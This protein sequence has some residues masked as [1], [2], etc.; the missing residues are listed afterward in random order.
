LITVIHPRRLITAAVAAAFLVAVTGAA[1]VAPGRHQPP[2]AQSSVVTYPANVDYASGGYGV[3]DSTVIN[4]SWVQG[5]VINMNWNSVETSLNTF[6]WG[7]LDTEAAA[8]AAK[9]KHVS[10][11]VRPASEV[12]GSGS[13]TSGQILPAWEQTRL[14]ASNWFCDSDVGD[15]VPNWFSSTFQSDWLGFISAL[16]SHIAAQSYASSISYVRIGVGLGAEGFPL[17]GTAKNPD[18]TTDLSTITASWGYSPD[19]FKTFQETMLSAYK[20]AI[21]GTP[22]SSPAFV[23]DLGN[24]GGTTAAQ[25]IT[26]GAST[27]AGDRVIIAGRAVQGGGITSVTDS[28]G[29]TYTV[30]KAATG[31]ESASSVASANLATALQSGDTITVSFSA[32]IHN[33]AAAIEA[34]GISTTSPVDQTA[35]GHNSSG[36]TVTAATSA[37]DAQ[38]NEFVFSTAAS[39]AATGTWSLAS[40]DPLSGGTWHQDTSAGGMTG[41]GYELPAAAS[42][43][44]ATYTGTAGINTDAD[45]VTYKGTAGTAG[46]SAPVLYPIVSLQSGWTLTNGDLVDL[47]VAEWW[48]GQG[49]GLSQDGFNGSYGSPGYADFGTISTYMLNN[50]PN[51]YLQFQTETAG[52]TLSQENADITAAEGY[53]ARTIEWYESVIK[54]PPSTTSMTNYQTWVTTT[55]G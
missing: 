11:V 25:V 37:N 6:N 7:P 30:D 41:M 12:P 9:G 1:S 29:N 27:T 5:V 34:S 51:A 38:A 23:Q 40:S 18:L 17:M 8:W 32:A 20:T 14:G 21:N 28:R 13:C 47:D 52:Q 4:D 54:S 10:L 49:G 36:L 46:I 45:I 53:R 42:K 24:A 26:V 48:L 15:V 44:S 43:F 55:F 39:T 19:N 35:N 22:G 3:Y 31:T 2:I 50:F 16:G 33:S